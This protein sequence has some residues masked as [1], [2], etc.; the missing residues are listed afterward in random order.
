MQQSA[1]I[2][3]KMPRN[4]AAPQSAANRSKMPQIAAI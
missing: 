1:A 3:R 2:R 4:A